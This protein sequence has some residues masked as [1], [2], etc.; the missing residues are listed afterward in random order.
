[1]QRP[2]T[3]PTRN[4]R[5]PF[6]SI[7]L[8]AIYSTR[9][10][11]PPL[12]PSEHGPHRDDD[13]RREAAKVLFLSSAQ[14]DLPPERKARLMGTV[15]GMAD[16][17][18]YVR[19]LPSCSC[20]HHRPTAERFEAYLFV[21]RMFDMG[22]ASTLQSVHSQRQRM[23][24]LQVEPQLFFHATIELPRAPRQ[25]NARPR[26]SAFDASTPS[27]VDQPPPLND[28]SVRAALASAYR[29]YRLQHGSVTRRLYMEGRHN[30]MKEL[31][32]FW[33]PWLASW[34]IATVDSGAFKQVVQ[35]LPQ[36]TYATVSNSAQIA[37]LFSQFSAS[38][39]SIVPI[40][41]HQAS[42]LYLPPAKVDTEQWSNTSIPSNRIA[43]SSSSDAPPMTNSDLLALVDFLC[44]QRADLRRATPP[45][46]SRA[47]PPPAPKTHPS[48]TPLSP[49]QSNA[50]TKPGEAS[51][52]TNKWASYYSLG[53]LSAP[54]MPTIPRPT[55]SSIP[56]PSMPTLSMP[57]M[58]NFPGMSN[59]SSSP[60]G[61]LASSE[62][63]P[64]SSPNWSGL[65]NVG[66][67]TIGLGPK[68]SKEKGKVTKS[69]TASSSET[70]IPPVAS[71]IPSADAVPVEDTSYPPPA[72]NMP[73]P[74][75]ASIEA[76]VLPA[77][78]PELLTP[79]VETRPDVDSTAL[80]EAMDLSHPSTAVGKEDGSIMEGQIRTRP[81][82]EPDKP[83]DSPVFEGVQ[84]GRIDLARSGEPERDVQR[85]KVDEIVRPQ[86][87]PL[88]HLFC[89]PD[90]VAEDAAL[91]VRLFECGDLM[92]ALASRPLT[93]EGETQQLGTRAFRLLEAI[94]TI[95]GSDPPKILPYSY[96]YF[97]QAGLLSVSKQWPSSENSWS[98][99]AMIGDHDVEGGLLDCVRGVVHEPMVVE[100]CARLASSQWIVSR[101]I[102]DMTSMTIMDVYAV[103]PANVRTGSDGSLVAA[104]EELRRLERSFP[105][106]LIE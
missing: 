26:S 99:K 96:Q 24:W 39:P 49:T 101:R 97:V 8:V 53:T 35:S 105:K 33:A 46:P 12:P 73:T 7:S 57:S 10:D 90:N 83:R 22:S 30:T 20:G 65:R 66:W 43:L 18:R 16:F 55:L 74:E 29:K 72:Q 75:L 88:L 32:S 41:L 79:A 34:N 50:V 63:A 91:E 78:T 89:G 2:T 77:C 106:G 94:Q 28:D 70:P 19:S 95:V 98:G 85:G 3:R 38:C 103:L 36:S 59:I 60:S 27:A 86:P 80:A 68:R 81:T 61:P 5:R 31:E 37:P 13:A 100:S 58:P 9:S 76:A 6:P 82:D 11:L 23:V 44:Q 56:M 102:E 40:L 69:E 42:V 47:D 21:P 4:Q 14:T 84:N 52:M 45:S 15:F 25:S 93:D 1:M 51:E 92:L 67:G 17:V 62:V 64:S 87:P 71:T 48:S 54:S 104:S